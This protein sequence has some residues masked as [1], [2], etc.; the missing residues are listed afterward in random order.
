MHLLYDG[1]LMAQRLNGVTAQWHA[2]ATLSKRLHD[3]TTARL[4]DNF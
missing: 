3:R 4:H 2:S 1:D